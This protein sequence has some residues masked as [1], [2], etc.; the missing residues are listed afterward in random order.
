MEARLNGF[1]F[2]SKLVDG[3]FPDYSRVIPTAPPHR[4]R[5]QRDILKHA[6][7]RVAI[8]SNE[9]FRGIR[10]GL[11]AQQLVLK[12]NNPEQE[13]AEEVLVVDYQGPALEIGFN[14]QYMQDV[15]GVLK[16]DYLAIDMTDGNS[17]A[18]ITEEGNLAKYVIMPMR[19]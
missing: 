15:L 17:S 3:R 6:L 10:F 5:I 1:I 11:T 14:V 18:L 12:A 19:I 9:K 16:A 2:S 8:L 7:H 13:E 4:L